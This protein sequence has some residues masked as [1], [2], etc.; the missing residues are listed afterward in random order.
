MKKIVQNKFIAACLAIAVFAACN[1]DVEYLAAPLTVSEEM[2]YVKVIHVAPNFT[3]L[4]TLADKV[5]VLYTTANGMYEKI[6]GTT[7]AY[8]NMFPTATN[9]YVAIN[10][11]LIPVRFSIGGVVLADS[12]NFYKTSLTL[13]PGKKYSYFMTDNVTSSAMF[14]EDD[15]PVLTQDQLGIRFVHAILNDTAGKTVDLYS[16]KNA[17]N[18]YENVSPTMATGFAQKP[19]FTNDTLIVRRSGSNFELARINGLTTVRGRSYT[20]VYRGNG[21]VTTSTAKPRG[22]VTYGH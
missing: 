18:L 19:F 22:L 9:T 5:N 1:K 10:S 17:A 15:V 8:D 14:F 6:N 20:V 21:G 16:V 7:L 12:I 11:G 2:S 3:T 4:T 13:R